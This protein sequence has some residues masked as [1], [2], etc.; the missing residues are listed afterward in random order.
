M[1]QGR[2]LLRLERDLLWREL[3]ATHLREQAALEREQAAR[4]RKALLLHMLEQAHQQ[5]QRLLDMP[6]TP[7]PTL[8]TNQWC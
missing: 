2:D 8:P 6:R 3:E 1:H 7:P 5:S 4:E